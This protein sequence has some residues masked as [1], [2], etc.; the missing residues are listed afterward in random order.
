MLDLTDVLRAT[1]ATT[2]AAVAE[3]LAVNGVPD[4]Y[5]PVLFLSPKGSTLYCCLLGCFYMGFDNSII[6]CVRSNV[7]PARSNQA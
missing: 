5:V 6:D 2:V 7:Q 1:S 3:E 4:E